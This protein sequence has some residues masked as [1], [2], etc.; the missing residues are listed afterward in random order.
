[1]SAYEN[2][3]IKGTN[4]D[5]IILTAKENINMIIIYSKLRYIFS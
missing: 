3:I 4:P 2:Q 5:N 1:M